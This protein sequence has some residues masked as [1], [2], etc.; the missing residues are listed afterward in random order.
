MGTFA[1]YIWAKYVPGLAKVGW[2]G[3]LM[4]SALGVVGD[5]CQDMMVRAAF[6][7]LPSST[8]CS[9]DVLGLVGQERGGLFKY[10]VESFAQFRARILLARET[11]DEAG[12]QTS[13]IGQ[14]AAAGFPGATLEYHADRL[15]PRGEAAPYKSQFWVRFADGLITGEG[16][17]WGTP[18]W[19]DGTVW[20]S[21][22]MSIEHYR[23]IIAIIDKFRDAQS[24]CHG[25][26]FEIEGEDDYELELPL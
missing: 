23:T 8:L 22:L 2:G 9:D 13:I 17:R 15:G 5:V 6:A 19:G 26:I 12:F 11:W 20:G 25:L 24:V 18:Y 4:T 1:D 7:G 21:H 14:L 3:S 10:P 16:A